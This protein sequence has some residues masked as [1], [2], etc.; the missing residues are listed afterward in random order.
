[1]VLGSFTG[2]RIGLSTVKGLAAALKIPVIAIS[3]LTGLAYNVTK[4]SGH[5]CS[6][7]DARNNQAYCGIFDNNYNL[8]EA[9]IADDIENIMHILEKY[10]DI[11]FVGNGVNLLNL[12]I[13]RC[14]SNI[15]SKNIGIAAYREFKNGRS[16]TSDSILPT[17]LRSSQAERMRNSNG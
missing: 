10:N 4:N 11:T 1:M 13:E 3:S 17:Y 2:I 14:D 15:H 6:L 5:I 7:I 9:Y 12:D 8:C 16:Q